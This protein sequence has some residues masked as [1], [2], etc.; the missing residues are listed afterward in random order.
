MLKKGRVGKEDKRRRGTSGQRKDTDRWQEEGEP[1]V[2]Q[3]ILSQSTKLCKAPVP[4]AMETRK[5]L[6]C[7]TVLPTVT[8]MRLN[9]RWGGW[10]GHNFRG[11]RRAWVLVQLFPDVSW[12][13]HIWATSYLLWSMTPGSCEPE[14]AVSLKQSGRSHWVSRWHFRLIKFDLRHRKLSGIMDWDVWTK[15]HISVLIR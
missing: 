2:G 13:V 5:A 10:W 9:E 11:I 8:V 15:T 4:V 14:T 3:C 6:S 12:N 1:C 7:F